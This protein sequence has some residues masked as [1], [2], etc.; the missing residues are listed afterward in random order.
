MIPLSEL[1][2]PELQDK[3]LAAMHATSSLRWRVH[4]VENGVEIDISVD[5]RGQCRGS[6]DLDGE[7]VTFIRTTDTMFFRPDAAFVRST[8]AKGRPTGQAD[9]IVA[10]MAG[11]WNQLKRNDPSATGMEGFCNMNALLAALTS[12]PLALTGQPTVL[13]GQEVV[14]LSVPQKDWTNTWYIAAKGAPYILK[15]TRSDKPNW[16]EISAHNQPVDVTPP[17]GDIQDLN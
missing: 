12:S 9:A 13:G 5:R 15:M 17:A 4:E 11:R 1:S 3:A 7:T 6:M 8:W 2:G 14:T 16:S 10:R